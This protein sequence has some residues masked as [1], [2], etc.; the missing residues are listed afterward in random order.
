[1]SDTGPGNQTRSHARPEG[2]L[3]KIFPRRRNLL[4]ASRERKTPVEIRA[5]DVLALFHLPQREAAGTLGISLSTLKLACKKL[6]LPRWP[7]S[8]KTQSHE[9]LE[10]DD[11]QIWVSSSF[12]VDSLL[13]EAI[14][15]CALL[16]RYPDQE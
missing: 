12:S 8:R 7:T 16:G 10:V 9:L 2:L 4:P 6:S 14:A 5:Q 1:M 11:E 13:Q 15:H 3:I